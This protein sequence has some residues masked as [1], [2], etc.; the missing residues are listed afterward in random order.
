MTALPATIPL[1]ALAAEYEAIAAELTEN[2]GEL[3]PELSARMD[4]I[5][6]AFDA[7]V[8]RTALLIRNLVAM[9]GAASSEAAR[10]SEMAQRRKAA[11]DSLKQYLFVQMVA[12]QRPKVETP[13]V[14]AR[15]Q[16]SPP[17]EKCEVAPETLPDWLKR[18]TV[19]FNAKA[20]I[21]AYKTGGT[22]LP[23]GVTVEVHQHLRLS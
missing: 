1:Y 10:L 19:A 22:V 8:E 16:N 11:A 20:A 18:T 14:T 7:K 12:A 13:L 17:S 23:E 21:D 6:E 5:G 15:I 9:A 2:G 4:A 3:T